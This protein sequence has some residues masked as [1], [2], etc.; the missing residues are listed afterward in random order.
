MRV[1]VPVYGIHRDPD[2]YFNPEIFDPERF[3]EENVKERHISHY[4]PFGAGPRNC[5]GNII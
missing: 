2:I 4:L 1:W 3:T 5:I